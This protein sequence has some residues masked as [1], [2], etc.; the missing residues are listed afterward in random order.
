MIR[1]LIDSTLEELKEKREKVVKTMEDALSNDDTNTVMH[2][3]K[4][5]EILDSEQLA[6]VTSFPKYANKARAYSMDDYGISSNNSKN[7]RLIRKVTVLNGVDAKSAP[8]SISRETGR[9]VLEIM[10]RCHKCKKML[11]TENY[12]MISQQEYCTNCAYS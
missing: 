9:E 6:L 10:R 11:D 4:E 5:I 8:S 1:S 3:R 7:L 2:C 12:V